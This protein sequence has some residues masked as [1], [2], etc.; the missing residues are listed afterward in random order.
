MQRVM[1]YPVPAKSTITIQNAAQYKQMEIVD[2]S[3]RTLL[4]KN[5]SQQTETIDITTL[6]KGIY[7]IRLRD[8]VM[9]VTK[10]FVKE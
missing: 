7:F 2:I 6:A 1:I 8:D 10:K 5:I 9:T 3:G 4:R